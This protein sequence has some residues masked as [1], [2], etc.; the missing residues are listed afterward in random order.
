MRPT[1]TLCPRCRMRAWRTRNELLLHENEA[2]STCSHAYWPSPMTN[3]R[4]S[5]KL[6]RFQ[7]SLRADHRDNRPSFVH[8]GWDLSLSLSLSLLMSFVNNIL[9]EAVGGS[10]RR[11]NKN[12]DRIFFRCSLSVSVFWLTA[13]TWRACGKSVEWVSLKWEIYRRNGIW[14][15]HRYDNKKNTNY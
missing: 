4:Y 13:S 11:S 1:G 2:A 14:I 9:Q 5:W 10:F 12:N 15:K 7:L 6:R 8:D 3:Y